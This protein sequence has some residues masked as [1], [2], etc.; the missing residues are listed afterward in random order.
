MRLTT[1]PTVNTAQHCV[2][3]CTTL[4]ILPVSSQT[5][6]AYGNRCC[7]LLGEQT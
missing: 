6:A 1:S 5:Q 7:R 2:L 3:V 4:M